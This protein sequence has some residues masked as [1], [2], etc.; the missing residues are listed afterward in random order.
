MK[1]LASALLPVFLLPLL[2][3]C[4]NDA[5][6]YQIDSKDNAITL[7]REQRW[8][9][10]PE[11]DLSVTTSRLPDCQRRHK[12]GVVPAAVAVEVWQTGPGTYLLKQGET[13]YLTETQTC[14][15]FQKVSPDQLPSGMGEKLGVFQVQDDK[16]R[17]VPVPP[18]PAAAAPAPAPTPAMPG[19]SAPAGASGVPAAPAQ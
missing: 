15:G 18:P 5:A 10:K 19:E 16:L 2:A 4:I 8:F 1:K 12:M 13:L 11:V 3:G 6:S 17:F 9:W 14:E 7:V